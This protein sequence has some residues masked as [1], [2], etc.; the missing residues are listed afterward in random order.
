MTQVKICGVKTPE[1]IELLVEEGVNAIGFV[2][3]EKSPRYITYKNAATLIKLIPQ[4]IKRVGLFVKTP[5]AEAVNIARDINLN[6]IQLYNDN[7]PS[8]VFQELG[9][10]EFIHPISVATDEDLS[11][12]PLWKKANIVLLDTLH[13]NSLGGTGK[14]F[15]WDIAINA[16]ARRKGNLML[17]GGLNPS[18]VQT[19]I[20]TV[21]PD[22]VDTSSGVESSLGIKDPTLIR[23]FL[24]A[25]KL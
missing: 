23:N 9:A 16:R 12:L 15:N 2:F 3:Y 6:T 25:A 22:W 13:S 8:E 19:A 24:R 20:R 10:I 14:T 7:S 18:N 11:E 5:I 1:I 17:A 4:N 21:S